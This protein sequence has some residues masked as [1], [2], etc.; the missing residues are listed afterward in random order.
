[1]T[2][3][4]GTV[5]NRTIGNLDTGTSTAQQF[6]Y[7]VPCATADGTVLT[8]SATT[9]AKDRSGRAEQ[10][11]SNNTA[12]ASTTIHAPRLTLAK[13]A[14]PTVNAGGAITYT[15]SYGNTGSSSAKNVVVTDTLPV[16]V[17]YSY[18]LDLGTGPKPS[19]V[20]YNADG[21]TTLIWYP[22]D[23]AAGGSSSIQYTA[24]PSLLFLGGEQVTNSAAVTFGNSAACTFPAVKA[25]AS[26]MITVLPPSRN[27]VSHGYWKTHPELRTTEL[28]ARTQATDQRYDGADGTT[29]NG[30]LSNTEAQF[31]LDGPGTQ[32]AVLR[33]QLLAVYLDLADRR[34]NAAT[35]LD[36]K[37]TTQLGLKNVR[38]A[39]RYAE[40]TLALP[41]G[42]ATAARYDNATRILDDIVTNRSPR[43]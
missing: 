29:P 14:T 34:I 28:L 38:D 30:A 23:V 20:L 39:V 11:T 17:Y 16:D 33:A 40:A 13:T 4:D 41:F 35:L 31:V 9:T 37:L 5:Q 19:S 25:A 2:M 42:P 1:D 36:S 6:S 43:Y 26:S 27:P 24:R 3:P 10:D 32:P 21:T 7:S 22:S 15:L 18:P 12:T 8:N